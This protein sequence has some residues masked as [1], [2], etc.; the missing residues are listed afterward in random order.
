MSGKLKSL[1]RI[2]VPAMLVLMCSTGCSLAGK[3]E[4]G[5]L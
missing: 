4:E 3:P 5:L 2:A 1:A